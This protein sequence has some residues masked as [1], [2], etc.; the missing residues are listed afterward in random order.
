VVWKN[1]ADFFSRIRAQAKQITGEKRTQ[2]GGQEERGG[3]D[4]RVEL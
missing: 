4:A 3:I 1:I 2:A